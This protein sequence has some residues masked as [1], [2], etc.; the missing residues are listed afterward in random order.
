MDEHSSEHMLFTCCSRCAPK[1][2]AE[3][4][5]PKATH[6]SPRPAGMPN[7]DAVHVEHAVDALRAILVNQKG[8]MEFKMVVEVFI[9]SRSSWTVFSQSRSCNQRGCIENTADRDHEKHKKR[10]TYTKGRFH[11]DGHDASVS[12]ENFNLFF[13][14]FRRLEL[15]EMRQHACYSPSEVIALRECFNKFDKDGLMAPL[16]TQW[17]RVSRFCQSCIPP[18]PSPLPPR[19]AL[20]APDLSGR[21]RKLQLPAPDLS[22]REL[23]ISV[24]TAGPPLRASDFSGRC[25]IPNW[26]ARADAR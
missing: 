18:A 14:N 11:F 16:A 13:K 8:Q 23:Q 6:S 25:R 4:S 21:C 9:G 3:V 26:G 22:G 7:L 17:V 12:R 20:R 15:E 10:N 19:R 2:A 1:R 24:G 5:P